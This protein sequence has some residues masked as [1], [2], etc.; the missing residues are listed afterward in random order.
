LR[1]VGAAPNISGPDAT[2]VDNRNICPPPPKEIRAYRSS[3]TK[4]PVKVRVLEKSLERWWDADQSNFT[5]R[6]KSRLFKATRRW[7]SIGLQ[8]ASTLGAFQNFLQEILLDRRDAIRVVATREND[9]NVGEASAHHLTAATSKPQQ[10]QQ[11]PH[12]WPIR[13]KVRQRRGEQK[14]RRRSRRRV[15]RR[16]TFSR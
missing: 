9:A 15:W 16:L 1:P 3:P 7:N 6:L 12:S 11:H 10:Q 4:S 8:P 2:L 5:F 14:S 13:L